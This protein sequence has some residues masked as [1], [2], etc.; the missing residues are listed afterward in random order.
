MFNQG[1]AEVEILMGSALMTLSNSSFAMDDTTSRSLV[2]GLCSSGFLW[3]PVVVGVVVGISRFLCPPLCSFA[4]AL[5][6][7]FR[8]LW[9]VLG[10]LATAADRD[11]KSA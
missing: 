2:G 6:V 9:G 10:R 1:S 7:F 8:Q 5:G 4:V 11:N 3:G